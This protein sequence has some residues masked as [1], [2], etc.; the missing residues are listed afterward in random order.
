MRTETVFPSS[1]S[2]GAF[3]WGKTL[4][5]NTLDLSLLPFPSPDRR[6]RLKLALEREGRRIRRESTGGERHF[7]VSLCY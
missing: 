1:V 4:F 7:L 6:R 5:V 3:P 2:A